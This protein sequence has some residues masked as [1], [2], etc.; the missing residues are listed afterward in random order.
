MNYMVAKAFRADDIP[1]DR[2]ED[3]I[4]RLVISD[5]FSQIPVW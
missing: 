5:G 1:P 3:I 4:G 2:E